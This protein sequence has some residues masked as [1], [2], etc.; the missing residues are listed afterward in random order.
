MM[1]LVTFMHEATHFTLFKKKWKNWA[2]GVFSVIPFFISF[3]AFKDDHIKH[4]NFNR[5]P[6]DPDAF[7]MGKRGVGDFIL[8]YAYILFGAA[9]TLLNFV[10]LYP[11]AAFRGKKLLIHLGE[12]T[13]HAV[14][15]AAL[16]VWLRERSI[17]EPFLRVWLIPFIFFG[18]LNSMR[19]LAEHYGLPWNRGQLIGT[20]TISSNQVNSFFWNNI[21]YHIGHHVYPGVPW[22]NL[23]ELHELMTPEINRVGAVVDQSYVMVFFDAFL[24]GPETLETVEA[25]E[26]A[27]VSLKNSGKLATSQTSD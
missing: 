10:A 26:A 24:H 1:G 2:F 8:F 21:N 27:R 6:K 18:Y 15:Y 16:I 9:L 20:R 25:R 22:Y 5:S 13:L 12:I 3:I 11:I 17:L 19:F 14:I 4:H 7:T 23:Q